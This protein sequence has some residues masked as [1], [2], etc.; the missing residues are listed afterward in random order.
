M[1]K[2]TRCCPILHLLPVR[3]LSYPATSH[4]ENNKGL[5][6]MNE[7]NWSLMLQRMLSRIRWVSVAT[8]MLPKRRVIDNLILSSIDNQYINIHS[9]I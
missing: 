5:D 1:S 2:R 7:V 6:G 4:S 8:K 9:I 3:P